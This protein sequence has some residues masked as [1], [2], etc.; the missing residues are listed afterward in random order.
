MRLLLA[1]LLAATAFAGCT[2]DPVPEV[3]WT[4]PPPERIPAHAHFRVSYEIQVEKDGWG[5]GGG[6]LSASDIAVWATTG[7]AEPATLAHYSIA[8]APPGS[9]IDDKP[10]SRPDGKRMMDPCE[11]EDEL[12]LTQ[13]GT[14]WLRAYAV[15]D[16]VEAWS[17]PERIV[18]N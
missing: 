12:V 17:T 14:Y 6:F 4:L 16:G 1:A 2:Q 9:A 5:R 13:P 7:D 11:R 10:C 3:I 8:T 15:I 18:A